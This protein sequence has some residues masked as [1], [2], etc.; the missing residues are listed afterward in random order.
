[1]PQL[2]TKNDFIGLWI[3]DP[4]RCRYKVGLPPKSGEYRIEPVDESLQF[5]ASWVA[6]DD[7]VHKIS[8]CGVPDGQAHPYEDVALADVLI[9][10]LVDPHTLDTIIKKNDKTL[11]HA[12][13]V[14]SEDGRKLT[15]T[16]YGRNEQGEWYRNL[17]T[18][19]RRDDAASPN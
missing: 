19:W 17:A 5:T 4:T 7:T 11:A 2:V 6:A 1:M 10:T 9:T 12:R 3:F 8:F 16:Q 15:V 13:R 18:Y 14:L